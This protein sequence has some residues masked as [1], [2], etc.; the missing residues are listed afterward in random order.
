MINSS[1][2]TYNGKQYFKKDIID[3]LKKCGLKKGDSIFVHSDL[4]YFGKVND[5]IKRDEFLEYFFKALLDV[6]EDG[7]NI[8]MP[9]FSYSFCQ[10]EIFDP[11]TTPSTV[12]IL[13]EYFRK[14]SGVKRS[15]DP[16]FSVS[17]LGPDK[18]YFTNVGT[19]CFGEKSIFEKL[20]DKNAKIIFL[21]ET[22]DITYMHFVE[23]KYGVPY[24]FIK[25]FK[26]K[27]KIGDDFKE[28]IFDYNVRPLDK[29]INYD[30]EK[31]AD[32]LEGEGIL[33]KAELGNSKIRAISAV[34]AFKGIIKG[35]KQ[36]MYLLLNKK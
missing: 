12:G 13:T 25:K 33:K 29:N 31:I 22:F 14:K 35:F 17:A 36:D 18:E 34:D 1:I 30:L 5:K 7:G 16:I 32:F 27:I 23:Q 2:F 21:G 4:R 8:I 19:N 9:T 10:K 28:L 3:S 15:I 24:R 20:Y 26:G 6:V 11:E